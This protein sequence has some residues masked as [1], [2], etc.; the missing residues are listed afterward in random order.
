M[1]TTRC[2]PGAQELDPRLV[3]DLDPAAGEERD[4]P[5]QVGGLGPLGEVELA[6]LGAELVVE[7]VDVAVVL[8]AD[9]AV[10]RLDDLAALRLVDVLLLE[11]L[12]REDVRRH[13]HRLLAEHADARLRQHGLVAV[14]PRG[15]PLLPARLRPLTA[16]DEVRV[17]DV[18]GRGQEPRSLLD[19]QPREQAAIAD[20]RLE[21]LRGC[22]Q[23]LGDLVGHDLVLAAR[24]RPQGTCPSAR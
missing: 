10:L 14:E 13:E 15:L 22:P 2:A 20:D 6:A 12:R 8:L 4:P 9:V 3:A 19:R 7:R 18:G 21:Q 24:H 17:E 16:L 5:A 1:V 11:V 23:L